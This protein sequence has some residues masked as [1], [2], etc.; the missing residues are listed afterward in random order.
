VSALGEDIPSKYFM[1]VLAD[2][3]PEDSPLRPGELLPIPYKIVQTPGL[4]VMMYEAD[5]TFRQIFTDRRKQPDNPQPAWLGYSVG[6]WEGDWMV[7]DTI[8]FNDQSWLDASGHPHSA[9]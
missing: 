9:T 3:K 5:T 4:M 8:G 6:K 2:F 7:V 1:N